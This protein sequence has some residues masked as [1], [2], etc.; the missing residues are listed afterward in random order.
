MTAQATIEVIGGASLR[1]ASRELVPLSLLPG[2]AMELN[3]NHFML[4]GVIILLLGLQF[5]FV[6]TYVLNETAT[7]FLSQQMKRPPA[8]QIGF[9]SKQEIQ[10][11]NW[12]GWSMASLGAVLVLHALAMKKPGT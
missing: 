4:A 12:L 5:R 8:L 6:N 9:S 2:K 3:R 1:R 11:P 10:P 7:Q